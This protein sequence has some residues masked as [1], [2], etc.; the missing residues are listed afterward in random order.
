[1]EDAELARYVSTIFCWQW[2]YAIGPT[3]GAVADK[4]APTRFESAIVRLRDY[5][6]ARVCNAHSHFAA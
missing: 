1:M 3:T 5:L 4:A 2:E 6:R